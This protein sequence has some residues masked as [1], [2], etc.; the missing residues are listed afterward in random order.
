MG[1]AIGVAAAEIIGI[2]WAVAALAAVYALRR[3]KNHNHALNQRLRV[4]A[5]VTCF[6]LLLHGNWS[7][8]VEGISVGY[9]A[10]VD[11]GNRSAN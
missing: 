10:V 11:V 4:F 1:I 2:P 5:V 9:D 6:G 7:A 8:F 3:L